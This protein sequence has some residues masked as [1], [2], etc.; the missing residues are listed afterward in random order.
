MLSSPMVLG[1]PVLSQAPR[2]RGGG[3]LRAQVVLPSAG[4][5]LLSALISYISQRCFS[6]PRLNESCNSLEEL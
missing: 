2:R 5:A 3:C 4:Q 6:A 1:A